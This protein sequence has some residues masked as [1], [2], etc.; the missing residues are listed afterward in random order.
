MQLQ[1]QWTRDSSSENKLPV[2]AQASHPHTILLSHEALGQNFPTC[3]SQ[4]CTQSTF[5][6]LGA[7]TEPKPLAVK[8]VLDCCANI[9]IFCV[10][11]IGKRLGSTAVRNNGGLP[12][13]LL[14]IDYS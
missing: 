3:V 7:A 1:I 4:Y 9:T 14:V 13:F 12:K 5:T 10:P 6:S 2:G 11:M 8:L